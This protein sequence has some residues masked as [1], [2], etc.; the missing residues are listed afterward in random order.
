MVGY[1]KRKWRHLLHL[2]VLASCCKAERKSVLPENPK[3]K[4]HSW[5]RA[6]IGHVPNKSHGSLLWP[7][8]EGIKHIPK[9]S[10]VV[11]MGH[12]DVHLHNLPKEFR[13]AASNFCIAQEESQSLF[14]LSL[15]SRTRNC[16]RLQERIV[17]AAFLRDTT[18][19][20][21]VKSVEAWS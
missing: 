18:A 17:W 1:P 7:I 12:D 9:A 15:S 8:L 20:P 10:I 4:V 2:R 13:D 11:V 5:L 6:Q 21:S 3:L 14:K 16:K 19:K